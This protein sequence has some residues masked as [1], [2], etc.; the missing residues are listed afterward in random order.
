MLSSL[1]TE[2]IRGPQIEVIG[3]ASGGDLAALISESG[4]SAVILPGDGAT[5]SDAGRRLLDDRARLRVVALPE[6]ARSGVVGSLAVH[7]VGLEDLSKESLLRALTGDAG[8][9]AEDRP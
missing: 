5:L 2:L 1:I 6:V 8:D 3:A 4:A 7:T 9:P